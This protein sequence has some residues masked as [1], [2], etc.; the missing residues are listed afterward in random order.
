MPYLNT[1][2]TRKSPEVGPR[3]TSR[4]V[5]KQTAAGALPHPEPPG[6]LCSHRYAPGSSWLS[7]QEGQKVNKRLEKQI[8]PREGQ[9]CPV[10][11]QQ[12]PLPFLA[13]KHVKTDIYCKALVHD[14]FSN[15]RLKLAGLTALIR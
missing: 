4:D 14:T 12:M 8:L 3:E 2:N 1:P 15:G 10:S 7:A 9:D 11:M 5:G 6:Q 13:P